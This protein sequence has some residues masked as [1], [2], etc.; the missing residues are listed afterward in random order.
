MDQIRADVAPPCFF[1]RCCRQ[2]AVMEK[3]GRSLC[4]SCAGNFSGLE[5]PLR[6]ESWR[7]LTAERIARELDMPWPKMGNAHQGVRH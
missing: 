1:F 5:Y 6:A 3:A 2:H 7:N 4:A